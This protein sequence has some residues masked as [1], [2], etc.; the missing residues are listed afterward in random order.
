MKHGIVRLWQ[1]L[2]VRSV[3]WFW[4][5]KRY[6]LYIEN[7]LMIIVF[8]IGF[9]NQFPS[10]N[11]KTNTIKIIKKIPYSEQ[12]QSLIKQIVETV[13]VRHNRYLQHTW[14]GTGTLIRVVVLCYINLKLSVNTE[15]M[16]CWNSFSLFKPTC[17]YI[18]NANITSY[19]AIA[20][21]LSGTVLVVI[22]W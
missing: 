15:N 16:G 1:V 13:R 18:F 19:Y 11:I 5:Q 9:K 20:S 10:M 6:K 2:S 14:L 21:K 4:K 17:C 7:E 22:E 12:F 8:H 3:G